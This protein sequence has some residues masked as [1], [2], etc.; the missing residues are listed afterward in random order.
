MGGRAGAL[1]EDD[2][3]VVPLGI[4]G[5]AQPPPPLVRHSA[6][7]TFA[8][9]GMS[10]SALVGIVVL[11]LSIGIGLPD[12]G[13]RVAIAIVVG[14]GVVFLACAST[15]VLT[16]ARDTY[17]SAERRGGAGKPPE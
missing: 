10:V 17:P 16:A 11:F 14:A 8:I 12:G 9:S 7:H 6:L 5:P 13:R 15:A 4:E 3:E 2:A 1:N